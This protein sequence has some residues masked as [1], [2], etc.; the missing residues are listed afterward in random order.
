[1]DNTALGL[2]GKDVSDDFSSK[3]SV[4]GQTTLGAQLVGTPISHILASFV[5]K[6]KTSIRIFVDLS[7]LF[8]CSTIK[9]H[10]FGLSSRIIDSPFFDLPLGVLSVSRIGFAPAYKLSVS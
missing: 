2:G 8:F 6:G 4:V 3:P 5:A 10:I 7:K 1:M 9:R